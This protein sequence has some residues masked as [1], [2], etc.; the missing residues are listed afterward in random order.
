MIV[1]AGDDSDAE[2]LQTSSR[3]YRRLLAASRLLLRL[4]PVSRRRPDAAADA[5][6]LVRE[7]RLYQADWLIR[8]YGFDGGE[9]THGRATEHL[10]LTIDPK[11]AWAL[12]HP[13]AFP[14][15]VEHAPLAS[16]CCGAGLGQRTV[17]RLLQHP[18][19]SPRDA[20]RPGELGVSLKKVRPFVVAADSTAPT[21]LLDRAD[22]PRLASSRLVR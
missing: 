21:R 3:L 14:V 19:P 13:E 20:A 1:G 7:H 2:I 6:P 17:T 16:G 8:F 5:P 9:L 4:Q 12:A 22:L 10:D 11:L 15:D 18:P